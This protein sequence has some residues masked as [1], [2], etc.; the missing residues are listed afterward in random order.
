MKISTK[1]ILPLILLL[2]VLISVFVYL[3]FDLKSNERIIEQNTTKIQIINDLSTRILLLRQ[4]NERSVLG[5]QFTKENRNAETISRNRQEITSLL[6]KMRPHITTVRGKELLANFEQTR[7]ELSQ[8][9]D[10]LI[11]A[12]RRDDARQTRM[13]YNKWEIIAG[14][15]QA[16]LHDFTNYNFHTLERTSE[17]YKDLITRIYF[18]AIILTLL[19]I[20]LIAALYF[21]LRG[22]ITQPIY[23]L[24][25]AA[26]RISQGDF[27][28]KTA[29][30]SHDEL[31]VLGKNLDSMAGKLKK[32]YENLQDEVN[33][34]EEELKRNKL[35]E[36]QKDDF[37]SIASHE[38]KTPV[39]SLKLFGQLM[40]Q[41]ATKNGDHTYD[42]Y[43]LKMDEQIGKLTGL[44]SSLL[45][46]TKMQSGQMPFK[47]KYFDL[48]TCVQNN[49]EV[50]QEI[51]KKHTIIL[52]GS[53]KE[54]VYGDEDR[55][56]QV[57]DNLISNAIKYS[58]KGEKVV[59]R[60][61]NGVGEINFSVQ[62]FGIGIDKQHQEKIFDRFYRVTDIDE[63]T[64]PGLGI[65]LYI[66]SEIIKRHDGK[67]WV[68][69]AKGKGSTFSFTI[70]YQG[71]KI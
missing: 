33:N 58:P 47:M 12:I 8:V 52:E 46:V 67:I 27:V 62:D 15:S 29:I 30:R 34:K 26:E 18:T 69:S 5:F 7:G 11:D 36:T 14:N 10:N 63:K 17:L 44:I 42:R 6:D 48:N 2:A 66:S 50:V 70:P 61:S 20:A 64:F 41:L 55:I 54:K 57:V 45:D 35:F 71:N 60:L 59:V 3:L 4:E 28:T 56:C 31:G 9:R 21:Y 24:S 65:G 68:E 51:A 25:E 32:Y 1:I 43:L 23:K 38:L 53:L 49:I 16:A 19:T 39:T 13:N 22:I 40:Q 37:V